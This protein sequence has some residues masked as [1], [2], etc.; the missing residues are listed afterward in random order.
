MSIAGKCDLYDHVYMIGTKGTTDEMTKQEKFDLFKQRTGGVLHQNIKVK[1][2][3]FNIDFLVENNQF[4]E[5]TDH[6]TYLYFN[7]EYKTIKSLNKEGI[8]Y[9]RKIHFDTMLDLV[10]YLPYIIGIMASDEN[11]EYIEIGEHSYIDQQFLENLEY[12]YDSSN[13]WKSN[14]KR[15]QEEYIE[16]IKNMGL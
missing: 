13:I 9:R 6:N 16:T 7:K 15:L 3:K 10:P 1:V 14:M 8:F 12:G 2:N 5:K 11:G 4:L